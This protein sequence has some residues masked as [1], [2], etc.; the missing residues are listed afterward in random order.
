[1]SEIKI[2]KQI[3]EDVWRTCASWTIMNGITDITMI[4]AVQLALISV[5]IA[6]P[7]NIDKGTCIMCQD[8]NQTEQHFSC[9][10][11]ARI[12]GSLYVH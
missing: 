10:M 11:L 8:N 3:C 4:L 2:A 12:N 7:E 5:L 1:M 9:K 6:E